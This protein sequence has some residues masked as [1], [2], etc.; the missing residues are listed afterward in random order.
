M[1]APEGEAQEEIE[2]VEGEEM[3][4][5]GISPDGMEYQFKFARDDEGK[6]TKCTASIAAMGLEIEGVKI[7]EKSFS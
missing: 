4:F 2:P 1:G 3:T 7:K 6:I 5:V